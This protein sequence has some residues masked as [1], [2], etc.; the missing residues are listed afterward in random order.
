[1][2]PY[3]TTISSAVEQSVIS[4]SA[5]NHYALCRLKRHQ[6]WVKRA[7]GYCDQA[8][9]DDV[10]LLF[11]LICSIAIWCKLNII[12]LL[13]SWMKNTVSVNSS[14]IN[15]TV[16]V[17]RAGD[18]QQIREQKQRDSALPDYCCVYFC[19]MIGCQIYPYRGKVSKAYHI[20][21][22]M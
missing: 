19:C 1:M 5:L 12:P 14:K 9:D 7:G 13:H 8:V 17:C 2:F 11:S 3:S 15:S 6:V 20:T 21:L 4:F 10:T 22:F 16:P 18:R